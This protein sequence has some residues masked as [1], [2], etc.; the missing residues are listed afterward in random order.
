MTRFPFSRPATL[1]LLAAASA[2]LSHCAAGGGGGGGKFN[3]AAVQPAANA[4]AA[5]I[6][7]CH[8]TSDSVQASKSNE[9]TA[10]STTSHST[11]SY[12][13]AQISSGG[14]L[15]LTQTEQISERK[16]FPTFVKDEQNSVTV[17]SVIPLTKVDDISLN[18]WNGFTPGGS[19]V[20]VSKHASGTTANLR[21][22][23]RYHVAVGTATSG[24]TAIK[25]T[26]TH[27]GTNLWGQPYSTTNT[28]KNPYGTVATFNTHAEAVAFAKDL[29]SLVSQYRGGQAPTFNQF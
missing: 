13:G 27:A 2:L 29:Q 17:S 20:S 9:G 21:T 12:S 15:Q 22:K 23:T 6:N 19:A 11:M 3:A 25:N 7:A 10:V 14:V 8:A 4:L 5:R 26:T 1:A 24:W 16:R 28:E 18:E